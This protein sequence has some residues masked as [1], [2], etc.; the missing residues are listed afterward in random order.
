VLDQA[1]LISS[2]IG[3]TLAKQ[4]PK[5]KGRGIV[6][7]DVVS[8]KKKKSKKWKMRSKAWLIRKCQPNS[9]ASL[10]FQVCHYQVRA[11]LSFQVWEMHLHHHCLSVRKVLLLS[12]DS[13]LAIL[14][15]S[16]SW[17]R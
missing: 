6:A 7:M 2:L 17:R 4:P 11:S 14:L 13:I 10:V 16:R 5:H 15:I 1:I 3:T 8:V 12:L 9:L